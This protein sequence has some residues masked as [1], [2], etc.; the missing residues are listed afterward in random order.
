MGPLAQRAF[1]K[2]MGID[3]RMQASVTSPRPSYPG[4]PGP[5]AA[6]EALTQISSAGSAEELHRRFHEE[7][8]DEQLRPAD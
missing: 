2:N 3:A 6:S 1:L 7:A 5:G 4:A 8:A